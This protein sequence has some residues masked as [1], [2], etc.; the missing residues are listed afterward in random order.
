MANPQ[1]VNPPERDPFLSITKAKRPAEQDDQ[2]GFCLKSLHY[3][4]F[5]GPWKNSPLKRI[6]FIVRV[7]PFRLPY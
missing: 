2:S 1:K 3:L 5:V 4:G 7:S 6:Q